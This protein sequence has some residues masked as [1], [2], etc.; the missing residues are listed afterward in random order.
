MS[1][2]ILSILEFME[3]ERGI[4]RGDMIETIVGAIRAAAQRGVNAGQELKIDINPKSGQIKAWVILEIVDAVSDP[5]REIHVEKAHNYTDDPRVGDFIYKEIDP[6]HLGRIA[7]QTARQAIFQKIRLMEKERVLS[8][9]KKRVGDIVSGT[10]RRREGNTWIVDVSDS[11]SSGEVEAMM[12]RNESIRREAYA[13]GGHIRALLLKIEET[14][15]G[16]EIILSRSHIQFVKRMLE[17]EVSDIAQGAVKIESIVRDPGYRSKVAVSSKDPNVDPVA[18][19][20][21]EGGAR[22]RAIVNQLGKEKVDIVKFSEDP[23]IFLAEALKPA[24]I[25][26]IALDV[27]QKSIY[28]EVSEDQLPKVIGIKGRNAYLT[29]ELIGW[30]LEIGKKI[31]GQSAF[32]EKRLRAVKGLEDIPGITMELAQ[33]LV[34]IG[35]NSVEAFEGVTAKDLVSAGIDESSAE[36]IIEG[37]RKIHQ[38]NR[39]D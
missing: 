2:Q 35:L 18:A 24:T 20:V 11:G 4:G 9:Y 8:A 27:D 16:P 6:S 12:P 3:K 5:L 14:S 25:Y 30:K 28:F 17:L 32:E 23:K 31:E 15:R 19:C 7:A 29:S 34:T 38:S 21:G 37:V 33:K 1:N 39:A 26:N 10:I 22:V 13:P 36:A